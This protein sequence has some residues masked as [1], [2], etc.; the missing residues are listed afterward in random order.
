MTSDGYAAGAAARG[1]HV[2]AA[3]GALADLGVYGEVPTSSSCRKPGLGSSR[4]SGGSGVD[5]AIHLHECQ[6]SCPMMSE[7][8]APARYRL[9]PE[10][11]VRMVSFSVDPQR[12]TPPS[13]RSTLRL[14][15]R[16][17]RWLFLTGDKAQLRKLSTRASP[18][19]ERRLTREAPRREAVL[20]ST[21]LVRWTERSE[22]AA[23]TTHRW[24]GDGA[25]GTR[26]P[27]LLDS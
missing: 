10:T 1:H 5:R 13:S 26:R 24:Q 4:E 3:G 7:S 2:D 22:F 15:R 6:S 18:P 8:A 9:G 11:R 12:D 14:G 20:H 19:R 27:R 21:R 25:V 17:E 23:T 16:P